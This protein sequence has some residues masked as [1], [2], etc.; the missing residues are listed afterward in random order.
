MNLNEPL[1]R[2]G[3]VEE[4]HRSWTSSRDLVEVR[5]E[6]RR[7]GLHAIARQARIVWEP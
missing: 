5:E 7:G 2:A 6:V 1:I 4:A 3:A